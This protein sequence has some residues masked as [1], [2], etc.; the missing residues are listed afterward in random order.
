MHF[1]NYIHMR[2][3]NVYV[4]KTF[5][6]D[7]SRALFLYN[8]LIYIYMYIY[9]RVYIYIYVCMIYT[10]QSMCR[11]SNRG[12]Q[13]QTT[14]WID[15]DGHRSI[16]IISLQ[17]SKFWFP[18]ANE[19]HICELRISRYVKTMYTYYHK[20]E[21]WITTICITLYF[22]VTYTYTSMT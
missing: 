13:H 3:F 22:S 14:T 12:Q 20:Y 17:Q 1:M 9:I 6:T 10:L 2:I 21:L 19:L 16:G 7:L 15:E 11:D 8:S 18:I 4:K 5:N